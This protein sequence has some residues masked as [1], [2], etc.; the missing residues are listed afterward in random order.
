[1]MMRWAALAVGAI[2]AFGL[3]SCNNSGIAGGGGGGSGPGGASGVCVGTC[4][5]AVMNGGY[6]CAGTG[7]SDAYNALVTCGCGTDGACNSECG[8]NFCVGGPADSACNGCLQHSCG[9]QLTD[10]AND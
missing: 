2:G 4:A 3:P 6:P 1:M 9:N 7:S 8:A 5:A 10:C